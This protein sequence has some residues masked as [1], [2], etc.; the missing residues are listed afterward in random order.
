MASVASGILLEN[1]IVLDA[2]NWEWLLEQDVVFWDKELVLISADGHYESELTKGKPKEF[3]LREWNTR[4]PDCRLVAGLT[5]AY[6]SP[7]RP[8]K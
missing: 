3:L 2:I 7:K 4:N 5:F 6:E 1:E 8:Q